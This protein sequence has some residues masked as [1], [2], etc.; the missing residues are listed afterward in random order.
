MEVLEMR[1]SGAELFP[2]VSRN[3][4]FREHQ[5]LKLFALF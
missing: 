2:L 4:R 1:Q 3:V 5:L